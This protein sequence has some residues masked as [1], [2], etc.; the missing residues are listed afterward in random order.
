MS[1]Q[2]E[3][4]G[5]RLYRFQFRSPSSARRHLHLNLAGSRNRARNL[6]VISSYTVGIDPILI[7]C[8]GIVP[9]RKEAEVELQCA[10]VPIG[11]CPDIPAVVLSA[12]HG[13][14]FGDFAVE[15]DGFIPHSRYC[16]DEIGAL[17][18]RTVIVRRIAHHVQRRLEN[19][20]FCQLVAT[21]SLAHRFR[22][23]R[24]VILLDGIPHGTLRIIHR[25]C[26]HPDE[27]N[28][29]VIGHVVHIRGAPFHLLQTENALEIHH[30]GI[31]ALKSRRLVRP[32]EVHEHVILGTHCGS[33]TIPFHH[34]LV[35][36]VH[37][38]HLEALHAH[39]R[40]TAADIF[41]VLGERIP[42]RPEDNADSTFSA[43]FDKF[44]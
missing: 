4:A 12:G 20:V 40:E 26:H 42:A 28:G 36:T 27:R 14:I 17:L 35:I 43:I 30:V 29:H 19:H 34:L 33:I 25:A 22:A 5:N 10:A 23:D 3:F 11:H 7:Y 16:R 21:C 8:H 31:C 24:A 32:M 38:V 41:H 18:L 15:R 9:C 6:L 39:F 44:L 37:E 2:Y 1:L 13:D